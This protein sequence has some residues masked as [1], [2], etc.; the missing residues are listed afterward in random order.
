MTVCS[1][2]ADYLWLTGDEACAVLVELAEDRS[3]LHTRIGRLRDQFSPERTHLLLEQA[4]LRRRAS[5][6]FTHPGR[7]FFTRVGLEQ[8]TD[9]WVA[10]HKA[11]RFIGQKAVAD[12]CCGIGGDLLALA[13]GGRV[14]GIDCNPVAAHFAATNS[15]AEVRLADA[16]EFDLE[17]ATA[18]HIDPDRRPTGRRTT[19]LEACQPKLSAIDRLLARVPHAGVK[20]APATEVPAAWAERCELEWISRDRECRQL[21]AWHGELAHAPGERRATIVATARGS[22]TGTVIGSPDQ[23]IPIVDRPDRCLFDV[24]PAVRAARLPG[25][26]AAKYDLHALAAGPS[27]LT[28][29][30]PI[31]DVALACFEIAAVLPFETRKLARYLRER[32]IGQ[33]EIKKRGVELDPEKL[34]RELKL[35][36]DI[37]A[38]LLIGRVGDRIA[39]MEARRLS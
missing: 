38:T 4:E 7:M 26:L 30:R 15:G 17:S 36:G 37:S 34:R 2:V 24:D 1:D 28:G 31:R 35:R 14:V 12:L 39:V 11:G 6:K 20:L 19:S 18:W 25:A 32:A 33:L 9:E 22:A 23:P 10:A 8:A 27:Y 13:H 3:A 5:A 29:P 21:V 16:L